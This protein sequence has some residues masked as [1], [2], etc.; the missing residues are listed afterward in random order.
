M[1][2]RIIND[3]LEW[4]NE[5]N[6][7]DFQDFIVFMNDVYENK[8]QVR[9]L[10]FGEEMNGIIEYYLI[11]YNKRFPDFDVKIQLENQDCIVLS[12]ITMKDIKKIAA[13]QF[14]IVDEDGDIYS[15]QMH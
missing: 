8:R 5:K 2:Q 1:N 4:A 3:L 14:E 15:I 13:N 12:C 10:Y 11:F 9:V 7:M 6:E